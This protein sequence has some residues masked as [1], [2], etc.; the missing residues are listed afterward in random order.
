MLNYC[1]C[2]VE[3]YHSYR[4]PIYP[5]VAIISQL[6]FSCLPSYL[7]YAHGVMQVA[8]PIIDLPPYRFFYRFPPKMPRSLESEFK[9]TFAISIS[10]N[11]HVYAFTENFIALARLIYDER[12]GRMEAR[13]D[14][15][16]QSMFFLF[17]ML[18]LILPLFFFFLVIFITMEKSFHQMYF[19]KW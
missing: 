2:L 3:I 8:T 7:K 9:S 19:G 13:F 1:I 16:F 6:P 11:W 15:I 17:I 12:I 4:G 10:T 18:S 14:S 5:V